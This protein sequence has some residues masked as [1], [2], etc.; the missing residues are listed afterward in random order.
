MKMN[1]TEPVHAESAAPA[2]EPTQTEAKKPKRRWR[3]L[4]SV[5]LFALIAGAMY[6]A[7]RDT[8]LA[9]VWSAVQSANPLWLLCALGA[10]LIAAVM[11]GIALHISLRALDGK[12][13]SLIRSIG[14]GFI[15]Q[16]YT[17]ITPAGAAGQPMQLYYMLGYGV[18][19]SHASLSLLLVNASHQIVVLLIPA[20]LFPFRASLILNNLGAFLWFLLFGAIVNIGLILFLLFAMFSQ[21]FVNRAVNWAIRLMTKIKIIKRPEAIQARVNKQIALYKQGAE[22]FRKHPWLLVGEL[23]AYFVLL[24]MQFVIPFFIYR[25]FGLS[26]FGMVDFIALQSILYLAVCFLPLPGS[27]GASESGFVTIFRVLFQSSLIV[28]AMLLS[29]LMSFYVILLLSGVISLTM[30]LILTNRRKRALA[31][32]VELPEPP[33]ES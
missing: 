8:S 27:A 15:G 32:A 31:A 19:V 21:S 12:R 18:E 1:Q 17:A 22:V 14:F 25:A 33:Q 24:G 6:F 7:L 29:R 11:F 9:E 10:S 16:Y 2:V 23:F 20:L 30:H 26:G 5:F 4:S 3:I 13:I 28:P